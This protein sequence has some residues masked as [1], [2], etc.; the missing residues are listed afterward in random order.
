VLAAMTSRYSH[1]PK[2]DENGQY[3]IIHVWMILVPNSKIIHT[4]DAFT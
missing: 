3:K 2:M 4:M 1:N